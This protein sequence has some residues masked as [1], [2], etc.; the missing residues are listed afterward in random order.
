MHKVICPGLYNVRL[1][2]VTVGSHSVVFGS[3]PVHMTIHSEL[4]TLVYRGDSSPEV[5]EQL[6]AG[7]YHPEPHS[8]EDLLRAL[9]VISPEPII[10]VV[11][12][13]TKEDADFAEFCA[14][15]SLHTP[16][17]VLVV[18]DCLPPPDDVLF[19]FLTTAG[20]FSLDEFAELVRILLA[21]RNESVEH[22][23]S[24]VR[25]RLFSR[26][27]HMNAEMVQGSLSLTDFLDEPRLKELEQLCAG[28][29]AEIETFD[30]YAYTLDEMLVIAYYFLNHG[31]KQ[32]NV[33]I[34]ESRLLWFLAMVRSCYCFQQYHSFRHAVDVLQIV[35]YF[36]K[37][38]LCYVTSD[39]AITNTDWCALLFAAFGHDVMHPGV[40]SAT[41]NQ[42]NPEWC[43][44]FGNLESFHDH[45]YHKLIESLLPELYEINQ[46]SEVVNE[47]V[48][49]TDMAQHAK[50]LCSPLADPLDRR[51]QVLWM[52]LVIKLADISNC[53]R[54]YR[55][56]VYQSSV[57]F[58]ELGFEAAIKDPSLPVPSKGVDSQTW[59]K[60]RSGQ[61]MFADLFFRPLYQLLIKNQ[62]GNNFKALSNYADRFELC[63]EQW[64]SDTDGCS[65]G[66][67]YLLA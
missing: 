65:L 28:H 33:E 41:C 7:G 8:R 22:R 31:L 14:F 11:P 55:V 37:R 53:S 5:I 64:V 12:S 54:L 59:A 25:S 50:F 45:L 26:P 13:S 44:N 67:E 2:P 66:F 6:S 16:T 32:A 3:K 17:I 38:N 34:A 9:L 63:I 18:G 49:A 23:R 36:N 4:R 30:A 62:T 21:R 40:S 48:L 56:S 15:I 46:F 39:I 61:L 51:S 29:L 35:Y 19:P 57:L 1:F 10:V 24:R 47:T 27:P 52:C 20:E 43:A 60:M 42:L 58:R